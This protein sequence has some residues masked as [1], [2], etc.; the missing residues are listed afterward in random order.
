MNNRILYIVLALGVGFGF[1]FVVVM[2]INDGFSYYQN[3]D[4]LPENFESYVTGEGSPFGGFK[5]WGKYAEI[6]REFPFQSLKVDDVIQIQFKDKFQ[7]EHFGRISEVMNTNP[8]EF[9]TVDPYKAY[10]PAIEGVYYP[11][12][13]NEYLGKIVYVH[14][15][16]E[17]A[18]KSIEE[19]P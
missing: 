4:S 9:K 12:S 11:I 18:L 13:E 3:T 17:S 10:S 14:K 8:L 16:L 7:V 15:D 19:K 5:K 1:S 6:D 2:I